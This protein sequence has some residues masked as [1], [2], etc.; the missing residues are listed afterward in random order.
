MQDDAAAAENL[1]AAARLQMY[2]DHAEHQAE[3]QGKE[4][5]VKSKRDGHIATYACSISDLKAVLTPVLR[6]S[7]LLTL[8]RVMVLASDLEKGLFTVSNPVG[9]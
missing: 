7:E 9:R 8:H 1:R 3:Q 5:E 4:A 6:R 2:Q